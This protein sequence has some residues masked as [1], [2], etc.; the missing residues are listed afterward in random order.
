MNH[1]QRSLYLAIVLLPAGATGLLVMPVSIHR[2]VF[3]HREKQ[4]LARVASRVARVGL[5]RLALLVV[6]WAIVPMAVRL[7]GNRDTGR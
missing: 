1:E 2:A 7:R 5:A 4:T 3:G 6:L